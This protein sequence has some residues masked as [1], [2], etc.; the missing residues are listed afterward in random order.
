M[1]NRLKT[2]FARGEQPA[3][4][5]PRFADTSI[6]AVS[7]PSAPPASARPN[8]LTELKS[9]SKE[10][11]DWA[12]GLDSAMTRVQAIARIK[13]RLGIDLRWPTTYARFLQWRH[14][15]R[16]QSGLAAR[17]ETFR[18]FEKQRRPTRQ[19]AAL[20]ATA[21][22]LFLEQAVLQQDAALFVSLLRL[23]LRKR[24]LALQ[25]K[26]LALEQARLQL[27]SAPQPPSQAGPEPPTGPVS[28]WQP[29]IQ[30]I[31]PRAHSPFDLSKPHQKHTVP[32]PDSN[33]KNT[34]LRRKTQFPS[35]LFRRKNT[36]PKGPWKP[37]NDL[38]QTASPPSTGLK[39][40]N[41]CDRKIQSGGF[42]FNCGQIV[43][44]ILPI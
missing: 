37:L 14:Q 30:L 18:Q 15:Q 12:C 42:D 10:E 16:I 22:A 33:L 31:H 35:P 1:L 39:R 7:A 27:E 29:P 41:P 11:I 21:A 40:D 17:L 8:P 34:T 19:P 28:L 3:A 26:K 2:E 38:R 24:T 43:E 32:A 25:E 9:R 4:P 20:E 13:E 6:K 36:T 44:I 23:R 5:Q